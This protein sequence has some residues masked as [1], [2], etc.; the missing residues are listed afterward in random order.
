MAAIF[1]FLHEKT[2]NKQQIVEC[3]KEINLVR[4]MKELLQ[5]LSKD[6]YEVVIISD[7]NTYFIDTIM[8]HH[9]LENSIHT[10]Y[11]NPAS[12]NKSGCLT[13]DYYH[14]QDWC[15]LSTKNLCK[16]HIFEG[17]INKRRQE[18]VEFDRLAFIGDGTNDLCP[19]LKLKKGDFALARKGFRL[20]KKA[21]EYKDKGLVAE[22]VEWETGLDI[23]KCLQQER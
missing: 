20:V 5:E 8:K 15:D 22:L 7:S 16:G 21:A 14:I 17:H 6:Q 1:K 18:G 4:G 23:L 11:S 2:I 3:M 13:I 12:F 10:V 9:R 19:C